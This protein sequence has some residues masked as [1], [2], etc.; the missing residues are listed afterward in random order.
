V[1]GH[2][3]PCIGANEPNRQPPHPST[4]IFPF[5]S[6]VSKLRPPTVINALPFP[7]HSDITY[8]TSPMTFACYSRA[9]TCTLSTRTRMQHPFHIHS[10]GIASATSPI[11]LTRACVPLV[12]QWFSPSARPCHRS[13]SPAL[14]RTHFHDLSRCPHASSRLCYM[15]HKA[16]PTDMKR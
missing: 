8:A 10:C 13:Q 7:L 4:I 2:G 16:V 9:E 11:T 5:T 12:S 14:V 15:Q 1:H 6:S 3:T